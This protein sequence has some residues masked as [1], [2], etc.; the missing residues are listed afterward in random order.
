MYFSFSSSSTIWPQGANLSNVTMAT[1]HGING[2]R[3]TPLNISASEGGQVRGSIH[4]GLS[5]R[6]PEA[7]QKALLA[8]CCWT[9]YTILFL[10]GGHFRKFHCARCPPCDGHSWPT[11]AHCKWLSA[12]SEHTVRIGRLQDT[13][14]H[15]TSGMYNIA[16]PLDLYGAAMWLLVTVLTVSLAKVFAFVHQ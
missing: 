11:I 1:P 2:F 4:T 14:T 7:F 5:C 16:S 3:D 12:A 10:I 13:A 6:S 8:D 15:H 9:N